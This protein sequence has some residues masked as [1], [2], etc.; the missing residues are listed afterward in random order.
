MDKLKKIRSVKVK[1]PDSIETKIF[2]VRKRISVELSS[3]HVIASMA[4][5]LKKG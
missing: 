1:E 2:K 3:Y 5:T 4:R